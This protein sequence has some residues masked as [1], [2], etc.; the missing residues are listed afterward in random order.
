MGIEQ[1]YIELINAEID[2]HLSAADK[3]LLER[4]LDEHDEARAYRDDLRD[5]CA[6][7][8]DQQAL[9]APA[10]IRDAVLAEIQP[11]VK[12]TATGRVSLGER[13]NSWFAIPALK[14]SMSFAAGVILTFTLITSDRASRQTFDDVT[15]L[16]GTI[17]S[18]EVAGRMTASDG[19][20]LTLNELAGSVSLLANG[21][22]MILDFDL[23]STKPIEI[24]VRFDN[25]DIWFNGFAQLESPGTTVAAETG[26]VTVRMDGQHR[27]AVYLHNSGRTQATVKLDFYSS[28]ALLHEGE[29]S[30]SDN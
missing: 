1:R 21:P 22:L 9:T 16:V 30:F 23:A 15:S 13:I 20:Q 6:L 27:Y 26:R 2:G 25:R 12:S 14:Y 19:L 3:A 4:Y 29:L 7:L 17:S 28:G 11:R 10:D 8:E 18:V 5:T 24:V